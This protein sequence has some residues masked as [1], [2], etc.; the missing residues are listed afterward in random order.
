MH[1]TWPRWYWLWIT[2]GMFA[3]AGCGSRRSEPDR[4]TP[5]DARS[6]LPFMPDA[7]S[8]MQRQ[9]PPAASGDRGILLK[10][11]V[12]AYAQYK[13]TDGTLYQIEIR[14]DWGSR[15]G[16][17]PPK[18]GD[19]GAV[20]MPDAEFDKIASALKPVARR[21]TY[22]SFKSLERDNPPQLCVA[23]DNGLLL[24]VDALVGG[25]MSKV[26]AITDTMDLQG[27]KR[28]KRP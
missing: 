5:I 13:D 8:A 18:T 12:G 14:D 1:A 28:I 15:G 2:I 19:W 7:I 20:T 11:M 21:G 17:F 27:L 6:L 24:T 9:V 3:I 10:Q 16:T 26:K 25:E 22:A 23:F 4:Y